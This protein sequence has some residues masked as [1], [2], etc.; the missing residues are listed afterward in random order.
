MKR[1]LSFIIPAIGLMLSG[2]DTDFVSDFKIRVS[3]ELMEHTATVQ[4][5]DAE[6]VGRR[7]PNIAIV[8]E[9]PNANDVY[10]VFGSQDISISDGILAIGLHPRANPMPGVPTIIPIT[11]TA[12][13]YLT[14]RMR[15]TFSA[16]KTEE[17]V[18]V[19]LINIVT[20]PPGVGFG[21]GTG[22]VVG[23]T[24]S[25]PTVVEIIPT[26]GANT[27]DMIVP[28]GVS[29]LN[30]QGNTISGA[31]L[32]I[33]V[34]YFSSENSDG[35]QEFPGGLNQTIM[36]AD[37]T[38]EDAFFLP[39]GFSNIDMT[40]GGEEVKSFSDPI[41]ISMDIAA[42][43]INPKMASPNT[44][45]VAGDLIDIWSFDEV[46]GFWTEETTD[47]VQVGE[48]GLEVQFTTTHLSAH[49]A[50]GRI[51][52]PCFVAS[53]LQFE[54]VGWPNVSTGTFDARIDLAGYPIAVQNVVMSNGYILYNIPVPTGLEINVELTYIAPDGS[55]PTNASSVVSDCGT[56]LPMSFT[57][58]VP[59]APVNMNLTAVCPSDP[60]IIVIP[61]GYTV[62]SRN[63]NANL[64]PDRPYT[65][66]ATITAGQATASLILGNSYDF[67]VPLPG[68]TNFDTT[69]VVTKLDYDFVAKR[70]VICDVI[71]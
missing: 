25:T 55:Q 34:A 9:G 51:A 37:G 60:N 42:G 49:S 50:G 18:S 31:N 19:N 3:P 62:F 48:N 35:M 32:D 21:G 26:T 38:T 46:D 33:N 67:R 4:I 29:F 23:D 54:F 17:F 36:L 68:N 70:K 59:P 44:A 43:S 41:S 53:E 71:Q 10:D 14:R 40:L 13:G 47:T 61:T 69:I 57:F 64:P 39:I 63:T 12:D 22:T 24:T 58:P 27:M 16:E 5:L 20:P 28:A 1:I 65:Q 15:V 8:I 66:L 6:D 2:C 56:A 30:R 45:Y 7:P 11:I 52:S